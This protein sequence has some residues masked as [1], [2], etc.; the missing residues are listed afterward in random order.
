MDTFTVF[1][2][3]LRHA[4]VPGRHNDHHPSS[5]GHMALTAYLILGM[6]SCVVLKNI[7]A[8]TGNVLGFATDISSDRLFALTNEK[9]VNNGLPEL[10]YNSQ[11]AAAAAGKAQDMFSK[12]YWAHF[13]PNGESPWT[14]ILGS[15]YS[16]DTAGEN[17]A[18]NYTTSGEVVDAWM[19]SP[20][21]RENVL[22]SSYRDVGFAVANGNLGGEDTTLVVQMFGS[23][24]VLAPS[25]PTEAPTPTQTAQRQVN[26]AE[27]E[28]VRVAAVVPKVTDAQKPVIVPATL[29]PTPNGDLGAVVVQAAYPQPKPFSLDLYP[30]FKTIVALLVAFLVSAFVID[31]Y[32]LSETEHLAHRGKH[33]AHIIF[34][35]AIL[36]AMFFLGRGSIL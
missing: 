2:K 17:L 33:I 13:G 21:H 27:S 34:L 8:Q 14:F 31:L 26:G 23:K 4:F 18:K 36:L 12:G 24:S 29:S 28:M 9:R 1:K 19:D 35:V 30:A 5:I 11:L 32:H 15:G 3:S 10:S 22:K 20:T 16:Y 6:A 7:G 25:A